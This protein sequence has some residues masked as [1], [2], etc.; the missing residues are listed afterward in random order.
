MVARGDV[1][2]PAV[3][4]A[5]AVHTHGIVVLLVTGRILDERRRV[6]GNCISSLELPLVLIF[7]RA[8]VMAAPQGISKATGLQVALETL[9]LSPP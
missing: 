5:I 1:L 8:R 3:R 7:N 2:D 6:A 9:R 4:E